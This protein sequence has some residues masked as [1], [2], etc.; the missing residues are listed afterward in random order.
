MCTEVSSLHVYKGQSSWPDQYKVAPD[1]PVIF[2]GGRKRGGAGGG[3]ICKLQ[4]EHMQTRV[5]VSEI[6]FMASADIANTT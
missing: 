2:R 1:A 4:G 5:A 3:G 6:S